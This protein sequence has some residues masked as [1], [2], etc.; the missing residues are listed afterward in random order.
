MREGNGMAICFCV[1]GIDDE[2]PPPREIL[3]ALEE[4]DFDVSLETEEEDDEIEEEWFQLK[5]YETS[6]EEP[7]EVT[8]LDNDELQE[9]VDELRDQIGHCDDSEVVS[10]LSHQLGSAVIGFRVEYLDDASEDENALLMCNVI[11][12]ILSQKL[13]GFFT[14]DNA[15][16]FDDTGEL[17]MELVEYE[18]D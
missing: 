10:R 5:I 14:V 18:E 7:I 12:Q 3:E 6:L 13:S 11:A 4:C 1:F 15:A 8:L 9:R 2:L 17:L 16:I